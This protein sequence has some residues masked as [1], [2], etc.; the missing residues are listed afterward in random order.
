MIKY[1][2]IFQIINLPS[3]YLANCTKRNLDILRKTNYTYSKPACLM[4]CLSHFVIKTCGCRPIEYKGKRSQ[5]MDH[6]VISTPILMM[7]AF[8]KHHY[9]VSKINVACCNRNFKF[10][11]KKSLKRVCAI[12]FEMK[13][14]SVNGNGKPEYPGEINLSEQGRA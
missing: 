4:Q 12:Q 2:V 3:P 5:G 10:L 11:L 13:F 9:T 14:R 6:P 1:F 8:V 7:S